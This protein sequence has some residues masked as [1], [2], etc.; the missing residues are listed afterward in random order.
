MTAPLL[1][2]FCASLC[3]FGAFLSGCGRPSSPASSQILRISQRNEPADLDPATASLPDE[4]FII[5]ALSEGLVSPAT[6]SFENP[7]SKIENSRVRPAAASH[8]ETSADGLTVT[9]HLRPD[10]RWSNGDP[11]TAADFIASYRRVLTPATAA[12]KTALFFAVKNARAFATGKLADFSAVGFSV[13]D[14]HTLV[15]TLEHPAPSFLLQA[16]SGPWIPTHPATVAAHGRDWTKPAYFVGNGPFTLAEWR[17]QQR[18]VVKKNP[19]YHSADTVRLSEI[20]FLRFDS[21][22][23]EERAYR[24]GQIDVTMDVPK[25][26]IETYLR[27]RP[28]ELHRTPLAETRFLS[29][30]TSRP[31]LN[32]ERVRRALSLVIDRT[33]I[34]DR[35][36]LGGQEPATRFVPPALRTDRSSTPPLNSELRLDPNE[37][38]RLLAAAGFPGGKNFPQLEL[39]GWSNTPVLEA[40]QAFWHQELGIECNL[41]LRE[42]TVHL[43]ALHEG[44]YDIGFVT[45]L[46][47]VADR[48][49]ALEDFTSNAPNNF[50][51]WHSAGFDRLVGAASTETDPARRNQLLADA[52]TLLL[53][54]AP[55]APLYFNTRNWLMSPRVHGWRDDSLWTR[56]YAGIFLEAH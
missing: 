50:P 11:V 28:A 39:T 55:V 53:T 43:A 10:A 33:K 8:W 31:P 37:A 49:A 45:T 2:I 27:E 34:V 21:A 47:D 12:R 30:N 35:I 44:N 19:S 52:E 29:F 15:V 48:T 20:Q 17:P 3:L 32:D 54:A 4:F 13:P 38:R 25:T 56:D 40:I 18:I 24:A 26:K 1:R 23:T 51:H 7:D 42:A 41:A 9:F 36:L 5:R 14:P 16:A 6:S 46:L 22:D